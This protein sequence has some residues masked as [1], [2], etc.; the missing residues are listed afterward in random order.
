MKQ[1]YRFHPTSPYYAAARI[2]RSLQVWQ[3]LVTMRHMP[4]RIL[5]IHPS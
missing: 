4:I 3:L 5:P 2:F 1:G